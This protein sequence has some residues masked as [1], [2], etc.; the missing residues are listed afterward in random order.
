MNPVSPNVPRYTVVRTVRGGELRAGM[1]ITAI[2]ELSYEWAT[3]DA[4]RLKFLQSY[5]GGAKAVV[6][7]EGGD[8]TIA[9]SQLKATDHLQSIVDMPPSLKVA[10]VVDGLGQFMETHGLLE[11]RVIDTA[12]PS[13]PAPVRPAQGPAE[14]P[15]Q[16]APDRA[17][18]AEAPAAASTDAAK[19]R[20]A[21]KVREVRSCSK[22]SKAPTRTAS[23]RP[24]PWK[25]CWI[26]AAKDVFP[27][28][29]WRRQSKRSCARD[30]LPP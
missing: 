26:R 20:K 13:A 24:A 28:R 15:A 4:R 22:P 18:S 14:P 17:P 10:R 19:A 30:P 27:A 11:F 21:E 5:F 16:P 8:K 3:L 6:A 23:G 12:S 9:I 7:V 2:T 25:K 29:A 1:T